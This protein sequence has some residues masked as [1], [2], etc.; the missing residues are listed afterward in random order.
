MQTPS[1]VYCKPSR[2]NGREL[3]K[4]PES[5]SYTAQIVDQNIE[6]DPD[7]I[8]ERKSGYISNVFVRE[9]STLLLP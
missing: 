7:G 1:G 6:A 9:A 3:P 8:F 2:Q 5:F 4:M